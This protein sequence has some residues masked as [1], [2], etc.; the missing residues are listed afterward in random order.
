MDVV[1][2]YDYE[3]LNHPVKANVVADDLIR[4][5]VSALIRDVCMRMTVMTPVLDTI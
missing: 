3:I 5:A 4:R 1:K 2:D